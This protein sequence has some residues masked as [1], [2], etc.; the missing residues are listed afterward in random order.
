MKAQSG[1]PQLKFLAGLVRDPGAAHRALYVAAKEEMA[2]EQLVA[3]TAAGD[4][5][6]ESG[7]EMRTSRQKTL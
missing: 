2:E 7:H 6:R 1:S 4:S 5:T 3:R